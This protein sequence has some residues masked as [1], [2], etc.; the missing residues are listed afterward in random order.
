MD[1]DMDSSVELPAL[2]KKA[3]AGSGR[4]SADEDD[5]QWDNIPPPR[6]TDR[7]LA[8][9]YPWG[10]EV[11]VMGNRSLSSAPV[12]TC[13]R[14]GVLRDPAAPLVEGTRHWEARRVRAP[15]LGRLKVHITLPQ[16]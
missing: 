3:R 14:E 8:S 2:Q 13:P 9:R 12:K 1:L 4:S 6:R 10:D 11:M 7:R 15:A 5:Y 16:T